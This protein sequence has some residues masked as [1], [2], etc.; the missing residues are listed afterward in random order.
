MLAIQHGYYSADFKEV[1]LIENAFEILNDF[2]AT[3][4]A[5]PILKDTQTNE[6][7]EI[8]KKEYEK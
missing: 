3:R 1:Y 4:C 8:F 5:L 2:A 6:E 7:L